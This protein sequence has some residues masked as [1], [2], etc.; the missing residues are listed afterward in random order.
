MP[1]F[2][3]LGMMGSTLGGGAIK[4]TSICLFAVI[5]INWKSPYLEASEQILP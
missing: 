5:V 2:Q 1:L 4:S 3:N